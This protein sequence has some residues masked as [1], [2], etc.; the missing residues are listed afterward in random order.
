MYMQTFLTMGGR[1]VLSDDCHAVEQVGL[2]YR[3]VFESIGKAG[4]TELF[5][6]QPG[7]K[8]VG[9]SSVVEFVPT[10]VSTIEGWS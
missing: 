1:F 7:D 2:N 8:D 10:A 6:C 4:I 3:R 9:G 5:Y